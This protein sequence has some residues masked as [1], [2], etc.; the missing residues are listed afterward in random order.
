M[1]LNQQP[2]SPIERIAI[3]ATNA[4]E[5]VNAT[6]ADIADLLDD[7]VD[8]I[9]VKLE[10]ILD[11]ME[12]LAKQMY[13]PVLLLDLNKVINSLAGFTEEVENGVQFIVNDFNSRMT[14]NFD[15]VFSRV[16]C[17]S[18]EG[19]FE[20][21]VDSCV[22]NMETTLDMLRHSSSTA[23]REISGDVVKLIELVEQCRSHVNPILKAKCAALN[24]KKI[25]NAAEAIRHDLET[26]SQTISANIQELSMNFEACIPECQWQS[27]TL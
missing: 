25:V 5:R 4:I 27:L 6:V 15:V 8:L 7:N 11:M 13:A 21:T 9:E 2:S 10:D 24:V 22:W 19:L 14:N 1:E 18:D 16:D 23:M 26:V 20:N 12:P 17:Q 3:I